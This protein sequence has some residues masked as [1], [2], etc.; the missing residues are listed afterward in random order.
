[1]LKKIKDNKQ[2]YQVHVKNTDKI[3][4]E[5]IGKTFIVK[6]G[7]SYFSLLVVEGMENTFFSEYYTTKRL[8]KEI[9]VKKKNKKKK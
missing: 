3:L 5:D 6:N 4:L 1:M 7:I 2:I 9:H 8:G